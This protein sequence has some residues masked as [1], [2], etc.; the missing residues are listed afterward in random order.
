MKNIILY[1]TLT[2]A[3]TNICF[4]QDFKLTENSKQGLEEIKLKIQAKESADIFLGIGVFYSIFG[5][6]PSLKQAYSISKKDWSLF[7]EAIVA[8]GKIAKASIRKVCDYQIFHHSTMK[9]SEKYDKKTI[10]SNLKFWKT[11]KGKFK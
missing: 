10:R 7:G 4:S 2:L 11:L 9:K 1:I 6:G 8:N 3:S 5:T